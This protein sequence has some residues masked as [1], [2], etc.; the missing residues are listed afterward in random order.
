MVTGE[1]AQ[2]TGDLNRMVENTLSSVKITHK[3]EMKTGKSF[4][5]WE[6]K[7]KND[8]VFKATAAAQEIDKQLRSIY[9]SAK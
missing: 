1:E 8:D 9:E 3:V 6:I 5:E 2:H 4:T 7:A